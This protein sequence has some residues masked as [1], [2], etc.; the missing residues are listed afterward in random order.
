MSEEMNIVPQ[1]DVDSFLMSSLVQEANPFD[2]RLTRLFLA[3]ANNRWKE[4][5]VR[6]GYVLDFG[7]GVTPLINREELRVSLLDRDFLKGRVMWAFGPD[8]K[9]LTGDAAKAPACAS[10][11]GLAPRQ[12]AFFNYVGQEFVDWRTREKVVIQPDCTRCPLGQ[13]VQILDDAGQP[14]PVMNNR[15]RTVQN[16]QG[17]PPCQETPSVVLWLHDFNFPVVFQASSIFVRKYLYGTTERSADGVNPGLLQ[18][19][20]PNKVGEIPVLNPV[21][22]P[23]GMYP[24]RMKIKTVR[25]DAY[26]TFVDVPVFSVDADPLTDEEKLALSKAKMAYETL[27]IRERLM[28]DFVPEDDFAEADT[29]SPPAAPF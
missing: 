11:N 5:R 3:Q 24:V 25:I 26:N 28:G 12:G 29:G 13:W 20:T 4:Q 10:S 8:G 2:G 9:R 7:D 6:N 22:K 23:A 19:Y 15:T 21:G 16:K 14:I 18:F 17:P 1:Q 27:K